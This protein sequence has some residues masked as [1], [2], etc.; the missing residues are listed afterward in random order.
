MTQR[1]RKERAAIRRQLQQDGILPPPKKRLNRKQ[2][3]EEVLSEYR[4]GGDIDNWRL[5]NVDIPRAISVMTAI[6]KVDG[7]TPEQVGVL[8]VLRIAMDT[9]RWCKQAAADGRN[10]TILEYV[11]EVA[12]P[13]INL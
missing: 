12:D 5:Y 10:P 9:Q 11:D 2:F 7:V 8:K 3:A 1:E 6:V 4:G 13:I